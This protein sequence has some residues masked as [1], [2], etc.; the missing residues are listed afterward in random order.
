MLDS[1]YGVETTQSRIRHLS[2]HFRGFENDIL[3]QNLD[4]SATDQQMAVDL[5]M[6]ESFGDVFR[7]FGTT[8]IRSMSMFTSLFQRSNYR[9]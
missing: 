4:K 1:A 2:Q 8:S 5:A 3:E 6:H 9:D 7:S